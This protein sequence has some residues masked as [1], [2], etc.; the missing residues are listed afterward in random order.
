MRSRRNGTACERQAAEWPRGYGADDP[1]AYWSHLTEE[2]QQECLRVRQ[3]YK[4]AF[5]ALK[6]AHEQDAGHG[7]NERCQDCTWPFGKM[8]PAA[9]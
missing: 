4:S 7:R 5:W 9:L 3:A 2:E 8:P 1:G 6:R